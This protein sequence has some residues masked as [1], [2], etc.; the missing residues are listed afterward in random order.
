[1]LLAHDQVLALIHR[2]NFLMTIFVLHYALITGAA[3]DGYSHLVE[4]LLQFV[5][6]ELVEGLDDGSVLGEVYGRRA[7]LVFDVR[8]GTALQ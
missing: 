7:L 8:L 4:A 5:L 6:A 3:Q 1:M 2:H